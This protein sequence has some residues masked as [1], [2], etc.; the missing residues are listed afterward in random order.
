MQLKQDKKA[1]KKKRTPVGVLFLS[2]K[3]VKPRPLGRGG[4]QVKVNNK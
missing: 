1:Y 3:G 4:C 2:D